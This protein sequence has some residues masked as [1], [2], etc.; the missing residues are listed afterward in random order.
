MEFLMEFSIAM[1]MTILI[2]PHLRCDFPFPITISGKSPLNPI[3]LWF[4]YGF[5]MVFL[6]LNHPWGWDHIL[7]MSSEDFVRH[8]TE[9]GQSS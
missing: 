6:W 7:E 1:G 9:A 5:P 8:S 2:L 3:Q 4:S